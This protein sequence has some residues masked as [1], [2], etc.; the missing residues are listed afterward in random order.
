M[1]REGTSE[2]A[3]SA[4]SSLCVNQRHITTPLHDQERQKHV[5]ARAPYVLA[6]GYGDHEQQGKHCETNTEERHKKRF[7]GEC[8]AEKW[9]EN[10]EKLVTLS[11]Q[12]PR[13]LGAT[14]ALVVHL[15][16]IYGS[17]PIEA[18]PGGGGGGGEADSGGGGGTEDRGIGDAY[19]AGAGVG[20]S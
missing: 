13:I 18:G 1:R 20:G 15:L 14:L 11:A 2:A 19:S 3:W 5:H 6:P 17:T 7:S 10:R 12:H 8:R 9:D 4:P 16:H